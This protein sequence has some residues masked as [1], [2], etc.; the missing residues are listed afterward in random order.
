MRVRVPS[1]R[2]VRPE[3]VVKLFVYLLLLVANSLLATFSSQRMTNN[4]RKI[5]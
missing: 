2:P 3:Y 4:V 1:P 5:Y